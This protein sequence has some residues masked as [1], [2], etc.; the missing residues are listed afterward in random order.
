MIV[1]SDDDPVPEDPGTSR[2][3]AADSSTQPASVIANRTEAATAAPTGS[4]M[5]PPNDREPPTGERG[6]SEDGERNE[7]SQVDTDRPLQ[8]VHRDLEAHIR[9]QRQFRSTATNTRFCEYVPRSSEDVVAVDRYLLTMF[10][11]DRHGG[12]GRV[13]DQEGRGEVAAFEAARRDTG[14]RAQAEIGL[15]ESE[16]GLPLA[17]IRGY[18]LRLG[19]KAN[20]ELI[21]CN[22]ADTPPEQIRSI[23]QAMQWRFAAHPKLMGFF[24]PLI[25][26]A[27]VANNRGTVYS[28]I[29]TAV[30]EA[31]AHA[32][33]LG[34]IDYARSTT[35]HLYCWP[36]RR[37]HDEGINEARAL[38]L[39][40]GFMR[41]YL[42][43]EKTN[44]AFV[45]YSADPDRVQCVAGKYGGYKDFVALAP[46]IS[47]N[48]LIGTIW[49]LLILADRT[50]L[51][52]LVRNDRPALRDKVNALDSRLYPKLETLT[53]PQ[54]RAHIYD[55]V[56]TN[57][58]GSNGFPGTR[59]NI[60]RA[61]IWR[62][63]GDPSLVVA[64]DR[65]VGQEFRE[66][67]GI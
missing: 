65:A 61:N 43:N 20:A 12:F 64:A 14:E 24:D 51:S 62:E 58:L 26:A 66:L 6:S 13:K 49:E 48:G 4:G 59:G 3:G 2:L 56:M 25:N 27:L 37:P 32:S 44:L 16:H 38:V 17:A 9:L 19:L 21:V 31:V 36:E 5:K 40:A 46:S 53:N 30:H 42:P 29:R 35:G 7:W 10:A 50:I 28:R 60:D 33:Q 41:L 63:N 47:S 67:L 11:R 1:A 18:Q 54:S 22:A 55:H 39:G 52:P 8:Q 34:N 23:G 45:N 15:S 57:I